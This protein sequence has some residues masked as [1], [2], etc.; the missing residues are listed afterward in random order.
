[1]R[2]LLKTLKREQETVLREWR[3]DRAPRESVAW[4]PG[5][6]LSASGVAYGRVTS[7]V[8]SDPE[9][10]PHVMVRRQVWTGAPPVVSDGAGADVRCYPTPDRA[11]T[12]YA[13]DEYVRVVASAGARVAEKLA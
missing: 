2:R 1:M 4:L 9:H 3:T 5:G 6:G 12:D 7:V 11:V 10:G 8:T 13:V